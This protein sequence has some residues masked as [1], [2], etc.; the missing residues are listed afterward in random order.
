MKKKLVSLLLTAVMVMSLAACGSSAPAEAPAEEPAAE[1]E[2]PAA[3][4]APAEEAA[5]DIAGSELEIA[6]TYNEEHMAAFQPLVDAFTA[7][8]GVKVN[9]ATY[10]DDYE[11]TLKTRMAANEMPD[12]W[13]THGWSILRYKEYLMDVTDQPWVADYDESALGVIQDSEDK[14][15]VLMI[16]ELVNATLVNLE[17]CE[18]AG[19]DPYSIHTW[20]DLLAACEKVKA[21]GYTPLGMQGIG[22]G[23]MANIAGTFVTYPGAVAEDGAAQLDGTWDWASYNDTI[24]NFWATCAENGYFYEDALTMESTALSE[25]FA[26]NKSAFMLGNDPG[27]L[28]TCL[29][30][31]PEG[32]YAFLP[33]FASAADGSEHVGI[34]EGDT[35]GIWKDTENEAAAKAF[36]EFMARPENAKTMNDTTGKIS[37]LKSSMDI[38]DSYGLAV[39]KEMKEKCAD[40]N[41]YYENLWD[42]Q[43]MPSGMWGIFGNAG[44]MLLEDW[45]EESQAEIVDYLKENFVDLWESAHEG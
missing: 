8:T 15:Y 40:C 42:R 35:F 21:A 20:D 34:G 19:V 37:C 31:N 17:V 22:A 1:E 18:A 4:E 9:V 32:K 28:V 33:T 30:L 26:A 23:G 11:A 2:A 29:S 16:S 44:S 27:V 12:I 43:W 7:E 3:E 6:V 36:L 10:G 24:M 25:R 13:Q 41:I 5:S 14:I 45:S 38:D 39:F